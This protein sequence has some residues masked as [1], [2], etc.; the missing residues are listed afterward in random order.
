MHPRDDTQINFERLAARD[1]SQLPPIRPLTTKS[2]DEVNENFDPQFTRM[3]VETDPALTAA[4]RA[5]VVCR[6]CGG[7]MLPTLPDS[8][9]SPLCPTSCSS[10]SWPR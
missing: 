7:E 6:F 5:S 4:E 10:Y 1:E 3:A 8:R 2:A 9:C